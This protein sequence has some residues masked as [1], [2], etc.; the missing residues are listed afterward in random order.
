M[1]FQAS[2]VPKLS[3]VLFEQSFC[4]NHGL[5][6]EGLKLQDSHEHEVAVITFPDAEG[7]ASPGEEWRLG[8]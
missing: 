3:V 8:G 6:L 7:R 1:S 4:L 2:G 5:G